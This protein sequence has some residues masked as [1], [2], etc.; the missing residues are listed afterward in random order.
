MLANCLCHRLSN[1]SSWK[2]LVKFQHVVK[3]HFIISYK[4]VFIH[5]CV[6]AYVNVHFLICYLH[7]A[8]W[9]IVQIPYH[10]F[11]V[12]FL[13]FTPYYQAIIES[14][15]AT[16]GTWHPGFLCF[17]SLPVYHLNHITAP[18]GVKLLVTFIFIK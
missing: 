16:I 6:C 17:Y 5:S 12:L 11:Q 8:R 10:W 9:H 7:L 15:S 13:R 1:Y 18:Y 2:I 3:A 14:K 4:A